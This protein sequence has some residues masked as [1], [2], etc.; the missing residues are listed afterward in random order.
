MN[1]DAIPPLSLIERPLERQ[2]RALDT[3][4]RDGAVE[5]C[6]RHATYAVAL[7]N[8]A[9]DLSLAADDLLNALLQGV[10]QH[11]D[12]QEVLDGLLARGVERR[13]LERGDLV[14]DEGVR[15]PACDAEELRC[16]MEDALGTALHAIDMDPRWRT[17]LE[18]Q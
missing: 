13:L 9:S 8:E 15:R 5:R 6:C 14:I 1:E 4:I 11:L 16:S 12:G 7:I 2:I 17:L 10:E 18:A 3:A